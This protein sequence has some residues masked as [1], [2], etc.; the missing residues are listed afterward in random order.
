MS[1]DDLEKQ[2]K[3]KKRKPSGSPLKLRLMK[4]IKSPWLP[5]HTQFHLHTLFCILIFDPDGL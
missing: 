4:P 5:L 3:H 1:S 2:N